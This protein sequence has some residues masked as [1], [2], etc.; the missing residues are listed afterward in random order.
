M[1]MCF[2]FTAKIKNEKTNGCFFWVQVMLT[3]RLFL[4]QS[5]EFELETLKS[6]YL[7]DM[8]RDVWEQPSPSVTAPPF[9][10][11][12]IPISTPVAEKN[13]AEKIGGSSTAVS[14]GGTSE[15]RTRDSVSSSRASFVEGD[16]VGIDSAC[17]PSRSKR[18]LEPKVLEEIG[19]LDSAYEAILQLQ[20]HLEACLFLREENEDWDRLN[21]AWQ[22][23]E[24]FDTN[25]SPRPVLQ[26]N[27]YQSFSSFSSNVPA[28]NVNA[29]AYQMHHAAS[30]TSSRSSRSSSFTF[31]EKSAQNAATK[32]E[33]R[34]QTF[35]FFFFFFFKIEVLNI[36]QMAVDLKCNLI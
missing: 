5:A 6:K 34:S 1:E 17:T 13:S 2:L 3:P 7:H 11:A 20:N 28:Q 12:N 18:V 26:T 23:P 36:F 35:S 19:K 22:Q 30:R 27:M 9:I 31:K 25:S 33:V 24:T 16:K 21:S 10:A 29:G 15:E 32:A 14:V 8:M 4:R